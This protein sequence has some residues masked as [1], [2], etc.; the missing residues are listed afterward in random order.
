VSSRDYAPRLFVYGTLRTSFDNRWAKMLR[1]SGIL[2][3]AARV[4]GR[5]YR[6]GQYTGLKRLAHGNSWVLGELFQ[7]HNPRKILPALD[8]YEGEKFNRVRTMAY[9]EDVG[10]LACWTYEYGPDVPSQRSVPAGRF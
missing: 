9:V 5:L 1:R 4:R 7:L 10:V 3:G 2:V 6:V 8:H